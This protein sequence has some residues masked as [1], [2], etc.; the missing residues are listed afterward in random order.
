MLA[1]KDLRETDLVRTKNSFSKIASVNIVQKI[2]VSPQ[3][4]TTTLVVNG[5]LAS[6]LT[7]SDPPFE[8]S[9]KLLAEAHRTM[10]KLNIVGSKANEWFNK[11][12]DH[13]REVN[14]ITWKQNSGLGD[15]SLFSKCLFFI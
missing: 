5:V 1:A 12:L 9:Q 15:L 11:Q 10:G 2:P 8:V 14:S 13:V 6:T 7:E 4:T 3:T